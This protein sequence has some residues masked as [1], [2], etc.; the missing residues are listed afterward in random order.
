MCS[1]QRGRREL[2]GYRRNGAFGDVGLEAT[3]GQR[4][5]QRKAAGEGG[6]QMFHEELLV[7]AATIRSTSNVFT[8]S[9]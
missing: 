6:T 9:R 4:G 1:G 2:V 5:G 8:S 3:T 7:I